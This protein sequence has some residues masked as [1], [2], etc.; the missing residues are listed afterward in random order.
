MWLSLHHSLT[1]TNLMGE[2]WSS[3]CEK[4]WSKTFCCNYTC[5]SVPG[6]FPSLL[7]LGL[8]RERSFPSLGHG[9][10]P[11]VDACLA[12]FEPMQLILCS[13]GMKPVFS[14]LVKFL[15]RNE[16]LNLNCSN[17]SLKVPL[18]PRPIIPSNTLTQKGYFSWGLRA[19]E[20]LAEPGMPAQ[21]WGT[22]QKLPWLSAK[23]SAWD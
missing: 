16:D 14:L 11:S 19:E 5:S 1:S 23:P 20:T 2:M 21:E 8:P 9:A 17:D 10:F 15:G 13:L 4:C 12:L 3:G 6:S 22:C 7:E 18:H